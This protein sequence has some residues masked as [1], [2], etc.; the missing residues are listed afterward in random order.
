M[1]AQWLVQ[2]FPTAFEGGRGTVPLWGQAG[3]RRPATT[4]TGHDQSTL[5]YNASS[6]M[7]RDANYLGRGFQI[8]FGQQAA[9]E[10]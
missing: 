3:H 10:E 8:G 1:E 6:R 7:A 2:P 9:C 4:A 5:S